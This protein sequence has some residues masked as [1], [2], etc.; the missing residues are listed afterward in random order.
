VVQNEKK[1]LPTHAKNFIG[2]NPAFTATVNS[3]K[4]CNKRRN[5]GRRLGKTRWKWEM[6]WWQV[7]KMAIK[8]RV[9]A[10]RL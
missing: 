1:T 5:D 10:Q 8:Q 6:G 9:V 4:W 3:E 2:P 7:H